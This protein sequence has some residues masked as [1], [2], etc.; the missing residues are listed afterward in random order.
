MKRLLAITVFLAA[1]TVL[2][3]LANKPYSTAD[4]VSAVAVA[5]GSGNPALAEPDVAVALRA[6]YQSSGQHD[7]DLV[8]RVAARFGRN[9]QAIERTDGLRGLVLLDRLDIEALFLYEKHPDEFRRLRDSLGTEAAADVLLHWREYFGLKHADNTDRNILIAQVARLTLSQQ[10]IVS[11]YP[12]V[13]PLI[14]AEPQASA[15]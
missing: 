3:K 2:F 10:K 7:R 15:L 11:R 4:R 5:A 9:A 8:A 12:S 1:L 6:K 13:L 14:L